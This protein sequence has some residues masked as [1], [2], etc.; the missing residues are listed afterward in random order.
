VAPVKTLVPRNRRAAGG[1]GSWDSYAAEQPGF[2]EQVYFFDLHADTGGDTLVL[3][4]NAHGTEGVGLGFNVKQLPCFT[5][6]KNTTA[7]ADGYVTGLE[8]GTNYPNPRT[9]E[10]KQGRV[11]KLAGRGKQSFAVR[12]DWHRDPEVVQGAEQQIARIQAGRNAKIFDKPQKGWC[13]D[14]S[15]WMDD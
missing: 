8:P 4:K 12:L 1:I 2:E 14:S 3:L 7:V 13:D 15:K 5:Q 11:V 10:G 6:W 9:F